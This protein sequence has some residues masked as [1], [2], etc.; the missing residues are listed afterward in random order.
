MS[1][2]SWGRATKRCVWRSPD[3]QAPYYWVDESLLDVPLNELAVV[4]P[5]QISAL[6]DVFEARLSAKF[7][8]GQLQAH[9]NPKPAMS[10]Q[11]PPANCD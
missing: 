5:D 3:T 1:R 8:N 11:V 2:N 9:R 10:T 6:R 7:G 4:T